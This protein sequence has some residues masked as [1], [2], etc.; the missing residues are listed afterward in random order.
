MSRLVYETPSASAGSAVQD[1]VFRHVSRTVLLSS[2]PQDRCRSP[3]LAYAQTSP[4]HFALY[5]LTSPYHITQ[6]QH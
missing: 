6:L 1:A 5:V 2:G 4:G 3:T